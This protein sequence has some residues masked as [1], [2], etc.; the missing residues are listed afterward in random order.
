MR[1]HALVHKLDAPTGQNVLSEEPVIEE[2]D[3][4]ADGEKVITSE[5]E[6]F[7]FVVV[8]DDKLEEDPLAENIIF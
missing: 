6:V 5:T 1:Y 7:N 3:V 8:E 2:R 4:V